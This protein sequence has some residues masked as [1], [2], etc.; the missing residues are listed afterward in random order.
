MDPRIPTGLLVTYTILIVL[1]LSAVGYG[2]RLEHPTDERLMRLMGWPTT[3]ALTGL[4]WTGLVACAVVASLRASPAVGA[5]CLAAITVG[6]L[7]LRTFPPAWFTGFGYVGPSTSEFLDVFL[8]IGGVLPGGQGT[9]TFTVL[10]AVLAVLT[11]LRVVQVA[12]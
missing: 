2:A 5:W 11:V 4:A 10:C 6:A 9:L 3:L 7:T 8:L 1:W 12:R